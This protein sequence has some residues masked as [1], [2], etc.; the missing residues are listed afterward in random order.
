[1]L[2]YYKVGYK[3]KEICNTL[4]NQ[5]V[6]LN[7][8]ENNTPIYRGESCPGCKS[9]MEVNRR[10][11]QTGRDLPLGEAK[12]VIIIYEAIQC[13]CSSCGL[14]HTF[15]PEGI[16]MNP[17]AT[18]RLMYYVC[19]LCRFMPVDKV[20]EFI[21]IS[22]S[23]ARRW[24]K[25]I[26]TTTLGEPNLDNI[27]IL[28][29]DEKSLGKGHHYIPVVMNGDTEEI[30]HIAEGKKKKSLTAFFDNLSP[31]QIATIK[32]VGIDRSGIYQSC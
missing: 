32:A 2:K 27:R 17:K 9:T 30:L 12:I 14:Y 18:N 5:G 4:I 26:L 7:K 20:T 11:I 25:Q 28:L 31:Q 1:V 19:K 6:T 23:T 24:D 16:D 21:P 8:H 10:V 3:K 13:H 22:T 15:T 29:I